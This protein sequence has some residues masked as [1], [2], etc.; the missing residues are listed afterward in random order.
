MFDTDLEENLHKQHL[1][2]N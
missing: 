1:K 2:L